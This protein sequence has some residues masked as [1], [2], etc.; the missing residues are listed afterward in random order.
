MVPPPFRSQVIT[1]SR[2]SKAAD[3]YSYGMV[4]WELLT[5]QQP[6]D[7]GETPWQIMQLVQVRRHAIQIN[8]ACPPG[9]GSARRAQLSAAELQERRLV[10]AADGS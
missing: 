1:A 10:C 5:W 7:S 6:F 3:V 2:F 4:A 9:L 8:R